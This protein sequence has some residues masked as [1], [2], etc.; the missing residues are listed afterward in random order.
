MLVF[1]VDWR[2]TST[3]RLPV[4]KQAKQ[5]K[6]HALSRMAY[7][8]PLEKRDSNSKPLLLHNSIIVLLFW[9]ATGEVQIRT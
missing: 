6:T 5:P 3:L 8:V 2:V 9:R 7:Y 4:G 1:T